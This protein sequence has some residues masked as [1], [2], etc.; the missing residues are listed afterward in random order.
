[1]RTAPSTSLAFM[2]FIFSSAISRSC[3]MVTLPDRGALA[4]GLAALV[5]LGRLLQ[6]VAVGRGLGDEGEAAVGEGGDHHR[7]RH[8]RLHV[9]RDRVEF[10]DEVHDVQAALAQRR[11]D[12]RRRVGLAGGDLQLD[13]AD[14]L[15]RHP[16]SFR[17]PRDRG[18]SDAPVPGTGR[19]V[20]RVPYEAAPCS[21]NRSARP[22]CQ[23]GAGGSLSAPRGGE[24][25]LRRT[26]PLPPAIACHI[27]A[28]D[29]VRPPRATKVSIRNE[30]GFD[31]WRSADSGR[32]RCGRGAR[33][34][35]RAAV[36]DGRHPGTRHP[37]AA[38][39]AAAGAPETAAGPAASRSRPPCPAARRPAA[40][41]PPARMPPGPTPRW[42]ASSPC[43]RKRAGWSIS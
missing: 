16:R 41:M 1:M 38:R 26:P 19:R 30:S 18:A 29:P 27:V 13:V 22:A 8:A 28:I 36:P 9:L 7:D 20:S 33:D 35:A 12:R 3:A 24:G 25:I 42:P 10:L 31:P 32:E 14:D 39:T 4:D 43:C 15:L 34:R 11:A 40:P 37:G 17:C 2:S 6:E 21:G 23:S 5:D